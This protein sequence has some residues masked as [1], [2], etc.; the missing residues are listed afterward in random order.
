MPPASSRFVR[1]VLRFVP[2]CLSA[3]LGLAGALSGAS[4][5]ERG[6]GL[7]F[8]SPEQ[9]QGVPLAS[10]P[11]S[12]DELPTSVDLSSHLP[13][14]GN[15]GSQNSCVGWAVGYYLKSFQEQVETNAGTFD[16]EHVFSPAFI[17]NQINN[18][19]DGGALFIDALNLLSGQGAAPWSL[20]PY[21]DRD[22]STRPSENA[23]AAARRYRIDFW[24]RVNVADNREVKAQL[25]AGYPVMIGAEVD[26]H[27][28]A[29]K[30]NEV[31]RETRGAK[32]GGHAMLVCGYD[33]ARN[34]F[35]VINSWGPEWCEN[36]FGWIDYGH[37]RVAVREAYVAK[38][39]INGPAAVVA[40]QQ[41]ANP[42][43]TPTTPESIWDQILKPPPQPPPRPDLQLAFEIYQ[44]NHNVM[45][46]P[47]NEYGMSIAGWLYAPPRVGRTAQVVVHFFLNQ[48]G[49]KGQA[50][51]SRG[52]PYSDVYNLAATG[53]VV[54]PIAA[55][56][57]KTNFTV[58]IPYGA[59][60]LP[61][62]GMPVQGPYGWLQRVFLLAEPALYI[63]GFGV[64][65][66]A[67]Q[68]FYIDH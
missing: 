11:F 38:D 23:A 52:P 57:L 19:R 42:T 45:G 62:G 53:T 41:P 3:S 46:G 39:A 34:A 56:G 50:V 1:S 40:P 4:A 58:W 32:L 66:G 5:A 27:F 21:S 47:A 7:A 48:Y 20:M 35:R 33:D 37:F 63:D 68:Q 64:R 55:D 12:G 61:P 22:F 36:G 17:Y 49:A 2:A 6:L 54:M 9:L 67:L 44:V 51:W 13:P 28:R 31:W 43:V 24:R 26:E 16:G 60:N 29:L 18:G 30:R 14:P 25:H 59:F 15:Q 10:T 8:A 65:V